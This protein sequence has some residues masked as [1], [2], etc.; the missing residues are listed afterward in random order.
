MAYQRHGYGGGYRYVRRP[1]GGGFGGG[2]PLNFFG[3]LTDTVKYLIIANVAVLLLMFLL[4]DPKGVSTD[5]VYQRSDIVGKYL[6]LVPAE[7]FPG[8]QLWRLATYMFLHGGVFHILLNMLILWWFGSPL[9]QI[10][11]R[12]K[13][14]RYYFITGIGAGV[15]CVPFYYLFGSPV[16]TIIGASGAIFALLMAFALIY[17]NAVVYLWFFIPIKIKYLVI[18]F[19]IIEFLSTMNNATGQS[20]SN[21]ASIAHLSGMAVG[22]FYLR[23]LMDIRAYLKRRKM[24][25][26]RGA[27][28][29]MKD[30]DRDRDGRGPWLH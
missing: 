19:V 2:G 7:V 26:A 24:K 1:S 14:L 17:P 15:V 5:P 13:F 21:V 10:W 18:G 9:E 29:V 23:G 22:Y 12:N 11:G 28:R 3:P 30:E 8:L 20:A 16:A 6:S 27:Y 25:K 4:P